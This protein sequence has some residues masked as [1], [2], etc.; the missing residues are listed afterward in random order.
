[1]RDYEEMLLL[2]VLI[3][4]ICVITL[5]MESRLGNARDRPFFGGGDSLVQPLIRA[6]TAD[7]GAPWYRS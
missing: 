6:R 2:V 7:I 1:M 5:V 3:A 4:V